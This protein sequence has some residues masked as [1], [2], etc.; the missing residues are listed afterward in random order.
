MQ[1]IR[2]YGSDWLV[3]IGILGVIVCLYGSLLFFNRERL[4]EFEIMN[5]LRAIRLSVATFN[6]VNGRNPADLNE[7]IGSD[8][9]TKSGI[10]R[11]Y[12]P[13]SMLVDGSLLDP[14]GNPYIYDVENGW[15]K[16]T[17]AKFENW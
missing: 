7:L 17:T 10:K 12:I 13:K 11:E 14:F 6:Y 5:E 16:S 3:T 15:V 1:S 9:T 8:F 4:R 2:R